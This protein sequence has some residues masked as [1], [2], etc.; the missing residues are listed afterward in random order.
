[1]GGNC[2]TQT[3]IA[4]NMSMVKFIMW[5]QGPD[6]TFKQVKDAGISYFELSQVEMTDDF[7]E[8]VSEASEKYGVTVIS[9]SV[10]YK[11]LFG[12][13][14]KGL[15]LEKDLEKII[16]FNKKLGVKYVRDSLM[17]RDCIHNEKGYY[18][19][20]EVFNHYGK[21]LLDEGIKFYYHNHHFEFEKYNGKTG[22]EILVENTDPN[23]VGFELDIHWIQRAGNDPVKWIQRL[24][25]REDLVHLKDYRIYFPD[26]EP[27]PDIFRKEQCIQFAEI[28]EGNLDMKAII[29]AAID[30][31]AIYLPIEQD[32]TYG[33]DP[34]ACVRKSIANIKL[35]GFEDLI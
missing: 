1:M 17:P 15:D 14:S 30:G 6:V 26:G 4:L 16:Y 24:S 35:L 25:G 9:S 12:D 27:K 7:V 3:K 33:L 21:I 10:I 19:A 11:P 18:E 28:G 20:A 32:D 23:Y 8:R 31:G 13:N 5:E 29:N 22:F 2:M 34:F